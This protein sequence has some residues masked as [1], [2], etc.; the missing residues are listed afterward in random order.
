MCKP[1]TGMLVYRLL[2]IVWY[3]SLVILI[4]GSQK[5]LHLHFRGPRWWMV[6][7]YF[8]NTINHL[9]STTLGHE[10][11]GAQIDVYNSGEN[12]MST[13]TFGQIR[14]EIDSTKQREIQAMECLHKV[15]QHEARQ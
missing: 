3:A 11:A 7:P 13:S 1:T 12:L 15:S 10:T 14:V 8:R 5:I 9:S 6:L 2:R 4:F